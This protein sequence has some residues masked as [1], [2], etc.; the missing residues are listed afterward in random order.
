MYQERPGARALRAPKPGAAVR[1]LAAEA[2]AGR[3][4]ALPALE[5][6]AGATVE[7]P[8]PKNLTKKISNPLLNVTGVGKKREKTPTTPFW[9]VSS[10]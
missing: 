10:K 2:P 6:G 5:L 8:E 3:V 7:A 9:G 1:V 4:V